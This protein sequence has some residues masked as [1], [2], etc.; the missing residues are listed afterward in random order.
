MFYLHL[1]ALLTLFLSLT[2]MIYK[3]FWKT[4]VGIAGSGGIENLAEMGHNHL[5]F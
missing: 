1:T 5:K 3:A 2:A 4:E